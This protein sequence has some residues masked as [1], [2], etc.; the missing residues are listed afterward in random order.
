RLRAGTVE[1][2]RDLAVWIEVDEPGPEL[3]AFE[4]LDQP[5]VVLGAGEAGIEQ[6][7]EHDRHFHPVWGAERIKLERMLTDRQCVLFARAGRRAIDA[8][9][10]AA[11]F[12]IV[13]PDFRRG[14]DVGHRKAPRSCGLLRFKW[15]AR[16]HSTRER[17]LGRA[18]ARLGS[19]N[20]DPQDQ[21]R[22]EGGE[23][24]AGDEDRAG[25]VP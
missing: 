10:L 5:G 21:R 17:M 24:R 19:P 15:R 2:G 16:A 22:G 8:G 14:V 18:L 9:E 12:G 11:V 7:L 25:P 4:Y 3:L 6:L 20:V 23:R 1:Q 13:F